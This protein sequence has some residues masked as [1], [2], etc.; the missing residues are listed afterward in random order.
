MFLDIDKKP[1]DRVA[2]IDDSKQS[3][4]YGE[5]CA[6]SEEFEQSVI[7]RSLIVIF[8]QNSIGSLMGYVASLS[9]KIVPLILSA[10]TDRELYEQLIEKYAPQYIWSPESMCDNFK[11]ERL[12]SKCNYVLMKVAS[13]S[14]PLYKE[15]SLLLPT[16]GSTGS[17]KLV[18]HSYRN[19]EAN[20]HNVAMLFGL[21][22]N[23]IPVVALPM[24]YTMGLSVITSHLLV[25]AKLFI[26]SKS[27]MDRSFWSD[28]KEYKVSSFT[29]VPFSYEIMD[30]IHFFKMD[31][32]DLKIITQGGGKLSSE[33]FKKCSEYAIQ[34]NKKFIPTYGQTEGTAR[35]AFLKPERAVDKIGSIGQAIPNG[36][37][38][39]ID[40][41]GVETTEG[42]AIG[43]M[44]Y[45][46]ENVT[47][48][49]AVC[50]EDLQKGDDNNGILHT[51]DIVR[52]DSEG[53]YFIVGRMKRFLKI[54]GLRIGLDEVEYLVKSN[55]NTD[56]VCSGSDDFLE[57]RITNREIENAVQAFIM[58][59]TKLFH[60]NIRVITVESIERNET[61]KVVLNK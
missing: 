20:A 34:T 59:K 1:Q 17:P 12:F 30:K 14:P 4:T 44:I 7:S 26:S 23:E 61:G 22:K 5:L 53:F 13:C 8:A 38:S 54:F 39:I 11:G 56:C 57:I 25:G 32:P 55:F 33:L 28:L 50:K 45:R 43:E 46:G 40:S 10:N 21:T 19:I 3:V 31:L 47:L 49:Y 58:E 42:E 18:R 37:L 60:K 52:R 24:H 35:M 27:L 16:S 9:A 48:G 6:F 15:L 36:T 2:A 51:G 29:G 41:E